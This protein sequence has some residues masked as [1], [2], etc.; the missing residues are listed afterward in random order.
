MTHDM[1][2]MFDVLDLIPGVEKE[3]LGEIVQRLRHLSYGWTTQIP[4]HFQVKR[5]MS[6]EISKYTESEKKLSKIIAV[7]TIMICSSVGFKQ[8]QNKYQAINNKLRE[9]DRVKLF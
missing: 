4:G 2:Q 7:K 1:P 6:E 3:E 5:I 9:V 8:E